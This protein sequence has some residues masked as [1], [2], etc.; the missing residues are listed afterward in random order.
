VTDPKHEVT[1]YKY[2]SNGYLQTVINALGATQASYTYDGFGRVQAYNG[3][4]AVSP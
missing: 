1:G 3:P 2:D 4:S